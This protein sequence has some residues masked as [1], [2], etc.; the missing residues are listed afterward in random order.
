MKQK[1]TAAEQYEQLKVKQ[2]DTFLEASFSADA[3]KDVQLYE[4]KV[5]SGMVFKCRPVDP[6]YHLNT[7]TLPLSLMEQAIDAIKGGQAIDEDEAA[8]DAF[9][10]LSTPE[11]I[12]AI[13]AT[14][15]M[16]RYIGV[17]PRL[18]V[19]EVN[20]HKNAVSIERLSNTDF[21]HL[22][23]WA[24]RGT[25]GGDAALGLKTFRRRRK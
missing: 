17:E 9:N 2:F 4:V 12:D 21:A 10:K 16:V 6:E 20:G 24:R 3:L 22:V 25:E 1:L 11:K 14:V 5:P 18:I 13:Q 19:G 15:R 23:K 8:A 7:G